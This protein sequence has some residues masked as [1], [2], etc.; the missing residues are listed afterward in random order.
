MRPRRS[1]TL[2]LDATALTAMPRNKLIE[3]RIKLSGRPTFEMALFIDFK[4]WKSSSLRFHFSC[5]VMGVA[6]N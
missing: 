2:S 1:E 5:G 6:F 3:E 4:A